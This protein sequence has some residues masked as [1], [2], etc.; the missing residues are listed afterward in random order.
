MG[1]MSIFMD[2]FVI[3]IIIPLIVSMIRF[4]AKFDGIMMYILY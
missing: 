2:N 1:I 4:K 3:Q